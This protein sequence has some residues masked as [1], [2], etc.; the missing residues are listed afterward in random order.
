MSPDAPPALI[1][2]AVSFWVPREVSPRGECLSVKRE[3]S[4]CEYSRRDSVQLQGS[5]A[6]FCSDC[7]GHLASGPTASPSERRHL[8]DSHINTIPDRTAFATSHTFQFALPASL[9]DCSRDV[10]TLD[11]KAGQDSP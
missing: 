2:G 9:S 10:V 7:L 1:P 4:D 3:R 5:L 6:L 11:I 8:I